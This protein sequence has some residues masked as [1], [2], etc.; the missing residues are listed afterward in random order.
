MK[1]KSEDNVN[2]KPRIFILPCVL[3]VLIIIFLLSQNALNTTDYPLIQQNVFMEINHTVGQFSDVAFNITQLGD[4]A[5]ILSFFSLLF[6][7]KNKFWKI[8]VPALLVSFVFTIVLKQFLAVPRPAAV[9][10]NDSFFIIGRKL[11]GHNSTP[12]GHSI[13]VFTVLTSFIFAFMPNEIGKKITMFC[14]VI[15]LGLLIVST[16]IGVGAHYPFDVLTGGLIGYISGIFGVF[17][18]NNFPKLISWI[19]DIK[20]YPIFIVC[21]LAFLGVSIDKILKTNLLIYYLTLPCLVFT[22]YKIITVYVGRKK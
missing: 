6:V 2:I 19:G 21:F 15:S 5:V 13:T 14:L 12:S 20:F 10:D 8:V 17:I 11:T 9:Y 4:G 3:L 7:Y 1:K 16:R 22:L 18:Y